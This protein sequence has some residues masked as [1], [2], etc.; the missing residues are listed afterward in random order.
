MKILV[1]GSSGFIGRN[2]ID[3]LESRGDAV[4]R[5]IRSKNGAKPGSAYWNP[6]CSDMELETLEDYDAVVHLAGE[7]IAGRWTKEKKEKIEDSRVKGTKLIA[8][9]LA[10]LDNKPGVLIAAS[11]IGIYGDRGD[12]ILNE[13]SSSGSGFLADV[14]LR[15]EEALE[16]AAKAGIRVV[17]LRIGMVLGKD[18]G[19]LGKMLL[20]FKI[21]MGGVIGSGNQY[22][23]WISIYDLIGIILYAIQNKKLNG[24]INAITPKP[25]TNREFTKT[26]GRVL[27]RPTIFPLPAFVARGIMGEMAR[28]TMLASTRVVPEKLT[29]AGYT[30]S[31]PELENAL[32]HI[33]GA[34]E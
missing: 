8:G 15:W 29:A 6:E 18:G 11:A 21:G 16:P 30:F 28:E 19:A 5:L 2:L 7:S 25:V 26:L 4:T 24:P 9:S 3:V 17:K 14:A 34:N 32:T 20:P 1:T 12:E 33:L 10:K 13:S 31:Y 22:W 23:S 27:G